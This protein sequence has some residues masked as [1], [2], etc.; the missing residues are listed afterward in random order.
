[1]TAEQ[2]T[3]KEIPPRKIA[4]L[5][6]RG[7]WR[8]LT[9]MI[10]KLNELVTGRGLAP[11]GTVGGIYYNTPAEVD[12]QDLAWEVYYPLDFNVAEI[13]ESSGFGIRELPSKNVAAIVHKGSYRTAGSSYSILEQWLHNKGLK[14]L[15]PAEEVYLSDITD[16]PKEPEI[17][18]R[19]P[20][21]TG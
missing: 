1:M 14:A 16:S 8:Q 9:E 6:C 11:A 18:I 15:G 20:V 5:K 7:S 3:L 2:V 13:K 10:D 4:Y 19:L 21:S 17:E 12:T